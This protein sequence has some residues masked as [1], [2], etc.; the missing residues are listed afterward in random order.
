M[1]ATHNLEL[2]AKY[3]RRLEERKLAPSHQ[4][5]YYENWARQFL[6]FKEAAGAEPP[7]VKILLDH[8]LKS[9]MLNRNPQDWQLR[10]A[11]NAV[12]LLVGHFGDE[13]GVAAVPSASPRPDWGRD[14]LLARMREAIQLRHYAYS[15]EQSYLDWFRRFYDY[16]QTGKSKDVLRDGLNAQD[17]RD[18]L[19]RLAT[20]GRVSASTQNQAF[21]ALLFLF[22]DV[23]GSGLGSMEGTLRAKRGTRLPAVLTVEETAALLKNV[24][25]S[26]R[27]YVELLYGTG[28][29]LME[30]ARLRVKDVDFGLRTL[31]VRE[32]KGDKDR[33]VMLPIRTAEALRR[34]LERT[35]ALHDEDLKNG[36]GEVYLPDALERKYPHAGREW[37]WQYVFPSE[38]LSVDPRSGQVRRHHISDSV[39]QGAVSA[40]VKKA[41]IA[42]R[43]TVH[44]LRHSFATHL[45]MK[46][47]NIR[48]VQ[49][50]L[51]HKNVETTMIYTHVL[52]GLSGAP[53]SPL[54][55]LFK[56]PSAT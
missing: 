38:K 32:G 26:A 50:L 6:Q 28:M 1:F 15:T 16:V 3:R 51:G 37:A 20:A 10:Q 30:L 39:I 9:I 55:S 4:I 33:T 2:L 43:A 24:S 21:S 29:R 48:E 7:P 44:T 12:R 5:P 18:F 47:V 49:E 27:L 31:T 46:G 8:Y 56:A 35:K 34:R 40:A 19:T 54:D 11:E 25:G 14:S 52:R 23:L 13:I 42:K 22:R 53:E 17:V 36:F 41:G 45:L